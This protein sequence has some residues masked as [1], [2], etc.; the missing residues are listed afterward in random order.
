VTKLL[1]IACSPRPDSESSAGARVF[2]ERLRQARPDWDID[3]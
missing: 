3:V 2:V 1:H